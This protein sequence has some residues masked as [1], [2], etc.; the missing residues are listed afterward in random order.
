M[1][2]ERTTKSSFTI[3]RGMLLAL[4]ITDRA[5]FGFALVDDLRE[6]EIRS[7]QNELHLR[8]NDDALDRLIFRRWTLA[9]NITEDKMPKSAFWD[10]FRK[11]MRIAG[12]LCG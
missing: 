5:L 11:T 9:D 2:P 10:M 8:F 1:L 6:Q 4:A 7:G 3:A 12:C